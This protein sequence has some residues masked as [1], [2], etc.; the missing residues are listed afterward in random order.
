MKNPISYFAF[1]GIALWLLLINYEVRHPQ[2]TETHIHYYEQTIDSLQKEM[3]HLE[4]RRDTIIKEVVSVQVKWRERLVEVR[5]TSPNDSLQVPIT[6]PMELDSCR[7]VGMAL[8]ERI[9]IGDV[10]LQSQKRKSDMA[11]MQVKAMQS[12]VD[13]KD[14]QIKKSKNRG[15]LAHIAT[16]AV[17]VLGVIVAL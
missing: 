17:V 13:Q 6:I 11:M 16:A 1:I 4:A 3:T 2:I 10:M 14:E 9:Q 5:K 7:E 12:V 15:R 8:M